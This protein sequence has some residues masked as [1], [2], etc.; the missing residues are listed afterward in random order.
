MITAAR[1]VEV[2]NDLALARV[3]LRRHRTELAEAEAA[4]LRT[5][6][7]AIPDGLE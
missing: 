1:Y 7:I 4:F 3:A 6:G 5:L 2:R